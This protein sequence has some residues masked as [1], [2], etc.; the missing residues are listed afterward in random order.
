[1]SKVR[2]VKNS[3]RPYKFCLFLVQRLFQPIDLDY[4]KIYLIYFLQKN[5][6]SA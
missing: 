6:V 4:A 5:S 1:M 2:F 3:V